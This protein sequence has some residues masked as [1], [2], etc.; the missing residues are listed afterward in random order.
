VL[1]AGLVALLVLWGPWSAHAP[2][3]PRPSPQLAEAGAAAAP[4]VGDA[5]APTDPASS[6]RTAPETDAAAGDIHAAGT[7]A[8][9]GRVRGRVHDERGFGVGGATVRLVRGAHEVVAL[10]GD[11]GAFEFAG[12]SRGTHRVVVRHGDLPPGFVLDLAALAAVDGGPLGGAS[13]VV[14]IVDDEPVDVA[15]A[16]ARAASVVGRVVDARGAPVAGVV[17]RLE[18]ARGA[19]G[20]GRRTA[21]DGSFEVDALV[22]GAWLVV[23]EPAAADAR[24]RLDAPVPLAVDLA[25]GEVRLLPDLGV[26]VGGHVLAGLLVDEAGA[27]VAGLTVVVTALEAPWNGLV[28]HTTTDVDGRFAV[29]RLPGCRVSV[30]VAPGDHTL[31]VGER[32]LARATEPIEVDLVRAAE[33]VDLA[34]IEVALA[35]V[36][37]LDVELRVDPAW[38]AQHGVTASSPAFRAWTAPAGIVV[39]PTPIAVDV[40]SD[41][42]VLLYRRGTLFQFACELPHEP[43]ELALALR[44][45]EGGE[46]VRTLAVVPRAGEQL[47]LDVRFP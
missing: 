36:F 47:Q 29:G 5:L 26:G 32:R 21:A 30:G 13:K 41:E 16:L 23:V 15:F 18:L 33:R 10:S 14:R 17:V 2:I 7:S 37:T 45:A 4:R 46:E 22:P 35:Q 9:A 19:R 8:P 40:E 28:L 6:A 31:P 27:P 38:A 34:P 20:H 42:P 39:E 11:D 1:A 44:L 24:A 25:A 3:A 43:F 12:L